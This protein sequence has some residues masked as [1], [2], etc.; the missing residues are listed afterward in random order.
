MACWKVSLF[1]PTFLLLLFILILHPSSSEARP[2]QLEP[3][4]HDGGPLLNGTVK[5]GILWYGRFRDSQKIVVQ[6]FLS[7]LHA[8]T[9]VPRPTVATWWRH[10]E[11]YRG[12]IPGSR[13][14]GK[15]IPRILVNV[16][17][18]KTDGEYSV[19]KILTHAYFPTLAGKVTGG[20]DSIVAVIIAARDVSVENTCLGQCSIHGVLETG[21]GLF[22]AL[23]NPETE[24]PGDC[25]WPFFPSTIGPQVGPPLIPPNGGIGEDA[26]VMSLAGALA[27]SVTN[28]YG[29][30]FSS[31]FGR[32][33]MEAVSICNKVFGTGAIEGFAGRVLATRF[34]RHYNA[35]GVRGKKFLLPAIWNPVKHK[36]V[37]AMV[38]DGNGS[39]YEFRIDSKHDDA[40]RGFENLKILKL[41]LTPPGTPWSLTT[42]RAAH[43]LDHTLSDAVENCSP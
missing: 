1:L 39:P 24:C 18:E 3:L 19:G 8:Q 30:G 40:G 31:P 29:N 6:D 2:K 43:A 38:L 16:V 9:R 32:E 7:S 25:G 14:R 27:H 15:R 10:V 42:S 5:L 33:T 17:N 37:L 34:K 41:G 26:I 13:L 35:N 36:Y 11:A 12:A 28:P 23:G 4:K 20:D 21:R 22:I